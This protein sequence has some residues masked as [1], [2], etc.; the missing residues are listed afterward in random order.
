MRVSSRRLLWGFNCL[1]LLAVCLIFRPLRSWID[2]TIIARAIHPNLKVQEIHFHPDKVDTGL[3]VIEANHFEWSATHGN[4]NFGISAEKAW[5]VIE[6]ESLIDKS[7]SI[8][9][10][11]LQQSK[12]YLESIPDVRAIAVNNSP[13]NAPGSLW[14][15][16]LNSRFG[17]LEW[18]DLR[19]HF[20]GVL[21][22][23]VFSSQCSSQIDAWV[24]NTEKLA[25]QAQLLGSDGD[26]LG[27]PLRE[28]NELHERIAKVEQLINQEKTLRSDIADLD[29]QVRKKLADIN[30]E[31][32]SHVGLA[33]RKAEQHKQE[34]RRQIASQVLEQTGGKILSQFKEYAE[35]ADLLCRGS[36]HKTGYKADEDYREPDQEIFNL[37]SLRAT[38]VFVTSDLK[39]PF[40]MQSECYLTSKSPFGTTARASFRYQ[41]DARP[42]TVRL[43]ASSRLAQPEMVDLQIEIIPLEQSAVDLTLQIQPDVSI[44][45][46]QWVIGSNGASIAGELCIDRRLL[47]LLVDG[48]S[49][50]ASSLSKHL[51]TLDQQGQTVSQVYLELGGTWAAP[52]WKVSSIEIPQWLEAAIDVQLDQQLRDNQ[53]QLV[54]RLEEH[55]AAEIDK[56]G[57]DLRRRLD[58][59]QKQTELHAQTLVSV[60]TN[61]K[62][63]IISQANTEFARS[64][65]DEVKR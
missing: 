25:K 41:F 9:K 3:S 39:S 21:K 57:S 6:N 38:G 50:I 61:L 15:Q 58:L 24:T 5:V 4:R 18:N 1:L 42:F 31:F 51:E 11:L 10:A 33:K 56:L 46:A 59:A 12:M 32:E 14:Q 64:G 8:P 35:V 19:Q 20:D 30:A 60:A 26:R 44:A 49:A 62:T 27:N 45:S 16:Q 65:Q 43:A 55:A 13:S 23:N 7:V 28:N 34:S 40:R 48:N 17:D 29:S 2:Q 53:E 63:Q 54:A 36:I 22:L 52:T 47:P 37:S